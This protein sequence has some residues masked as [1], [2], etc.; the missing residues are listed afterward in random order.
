MP[1][2][3]PRHQITETDKIAR[4]LDEASRLWPELHG[5]R[6]KLL[7]RLVEEGY[8][9]VASRRHDATSARRAALAE[10]SGAL[11]EAYGEGYIA[12]LHAEWPA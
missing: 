11:T 4:A 7:V 12:A 5:N 3:R 2:T 9:A 6:A 8:S 1:T 10:I